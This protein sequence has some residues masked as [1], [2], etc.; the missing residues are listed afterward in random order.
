MT[1]G[2]AVERAL[3]GSILLDSHHYA[4]VAAAIRAE[5]FSLES[6]QRIFRRMGGLV[7][8]GQVVDTVTLFQGLM[9]HGE[10]SAIGGPAYLAALTE[11]LPRRPSVIAYVRLLQRD[12]QRRKTRS[13]ISHLLAQV[14]DPAEDVDTVIAR[15]IDRMLELQGAK[16]AEAS[17]SS[18]L[19]PLLDR[20]QVEHVRKT[21]LLG[22]STGLASL[23]KATR[24]MQSS[25]L[26]VAGARSGAGKSAF[27]AQP[28][29]ANCCA[30]IPVLV[31]SLEMTIE[32]LY[33]RIMASISGVPFAR[34]R[35]TKWASEQE[36]ADIR[37]A[38]DKI[39]DWPLEIDDNGSLHIDKLCAK[40]RHA[41]RRSGV[42][43]VCIDYAQI[44]PADGRDERLRVAAVSRSLA[45]LS[46]D[47]GVPVLLLSQ[48]SRPDKSN[49]NRRPPPQR[50]AGN[51]AA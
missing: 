43:L 26:W 35:D 21:E 36:M 46:K 28:V 19:V 30:G 17:T 11:G 7:A 40:A 13:E 48:L 38:A 49:A 51:V 2:A 15:G 29:I 14:E 27:M 31:F 34:V 8:D 39:A 16:H 5:D 22:L 50:L 42:R 10:L 4:E 37:C 20:M 41:I 33:R 24:G 47:E 23:D 45:R 12:A 18:R 44:V 1:D 9:H 6:H 3:L 32:Q 25:E